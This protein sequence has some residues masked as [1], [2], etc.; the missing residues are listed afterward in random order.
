MLGVGDELLGTFVVSEPL[1]LLPTGALTGAGGRFSLVVEQTDELEFALR[2]RPLPGDGTVQLPEGTYGIQVDIV[3]LAGNRFSGD[4]GVTVEL[5]RTVP[6]ATDGTGRILLVPDPTDNVLREV[7]HWR[8]GTEVEMTFIASE[9]AEAT[10]VL[11]DLEGAV[12]DVGLVFSPRSTGGLIQILALDEEASNPV[13]GTYQL[14]VE[15]VDRAGNIARSALTQLDG[16]PVTLTVDRAPP[17]APAVDTPDAVRFIR[18]PWG[19]VDG[20]PARSLIELSANAFESDAVL[21]AYADAGGELE[22]GRFDLRDEDTSVPIDLRAA[23]RPELFVQAVDRAGNRSKTARVRDIEWRASLV[24]KGAGSTAANPHRFLVRTVDSDAIEIFGQEEVGAP[25]GVATTDGVGTRTEGRVSAVRAQ[26][27][28]GPSRRSESAA[29]YDPARGII[30]LYGGRGRFLGGTTNRLSDL[31]ELRNN[32]FSKPQVFEIGGDG[33]PPSN[34]LTF[35][36]DAIRARLILGPGDEVY[37]EYDGA[38][39]RRRETRD[40]LEDGSPGPGDTLYW[41]VREQTLSAI[42]DGATL[43]N[44]VDDEWQSACDSECTS[45]APAS[46]EDAPVAYSEER[47]VL[48]LFG[49]EDRVEAD[50]TDRLLWSFDGVRW[51]NPCTDD[52]ADS[53]PA[54]RVF[55]A[56]ATDPGNG[57][58]VLFGGN[59]I[60]AAFR[61]G[62]LDLWR[63][64]GT[65]WTC[66]SPTVCTRRDASGC[67][68]EIDPCNQVIDSFTPGLP[69]THSRPGPLVVDPV[70]DSVHLFGAELG[71][72]TFIGH[73]VFDGIRWSETNDRSPSAGAGAASVYD[74]VDGTVLAFPAGGR[75][76]HR[77][78]RVWYDECVFCGPDEQREA[79]FGYRPL[80]DQIVLFAGIDSGGAAIRR[81]WQYNRNTL[82]FDQICS[83]CGPSMPAGAPLTLE[84]GGNDLFTVE[85]VETLSTRNETWRFDGTQW[86][87]RCPG[88][89]CTPVVESVQSAEAAASGDEAMLFVETSAFEETP[90]S[91]ECTEGQVRQLE[92]ETYPIVGRRELRRDVALTHDPVTGLFWLFGG[93]TNDECLADA[94]GAPVNTLSYWTGTEWQD[95]SPVD[96]YGD[97][98]PPA[99]TDALLEGRPK[100][101]MV[102][103]G[104]GDRDTWFVETG[105]ERRPEHVAR[106]N[107]DSAGADPDTELLAVQVDWVG[108][109]D[110]ELPAPAVGCDL[111]VWTGTGFQ[112]AVSGDVPPEA[113]AT[114][115]WSSAT[116][117]IDRPLGN[118]LF[119]DGRELVFSLRPRAANG[120][121]TA[122]AVVSTD[123]VGVVVRYRL[124][125]QL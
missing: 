7:K 117:A 24:G 18:I 40:D 65:G 107:F 53:G 104:S 100:G 32:A 112:T 23:D 50:D 17:A 27:E 39:L 31:W 47:G 29:A 95:V 59:P 116:L 74:P 11:R 99:G 55:S 8:P 10:V 83:N 71:F 44:L 3:D 87:I 43:W 4:L 76:F 115:Q 49:P 86:S 36:Y 5:D 6:S 125:P 30:A 114:L 94:F 90:S 9:P 89:G 26:S 34:E 62:Y 84:P 19:E 78:R 124:P 77:F 66:E 16:S 119:G 12:V 101:P 45:S 102:M 81:T 73:Y 41:N 33:P 85:A 109:C 111:R 110:G 70:T 68:F 120:S 35:A 15:L 93:D 79:A 58:L 113:P 28:D 91:R 20:S 13:D 105:G 46:A 22:I 108:G 97:G 52:C 82:R 63:W 103:F 2:G 69:D 98:Q 38:R 42:A 1:S 57:D 14:D 67:T 21:L 123:S 88:G 54:P 75:S 56:L 64:D 106:F 48:E 122:P 60:G 118:L 51:E 61:V 37:W 80:D 72:G 96:P 25:E 92:S 121:P